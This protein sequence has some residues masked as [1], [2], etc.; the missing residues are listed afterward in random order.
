MRSLLEYGKGLCTLHRDVDHRE[1]ITFHVD[2]N[3]TAF[4]IAAAGTSF[5]I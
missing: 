2:N 3:P 1:L 5:L 4:E